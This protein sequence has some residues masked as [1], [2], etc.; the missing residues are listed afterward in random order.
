MGKD[1]SQVTENDRTFFKVQTKD[2]TTVKNMQKHL[3]DLPFSCF[4]L[5]EEKKKGKKMF[6]QNVGPMSKKE[7]RYL[8]PFYS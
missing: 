3:F 5:S 2:E 4:I 7:G 6:R 1:G 8:K